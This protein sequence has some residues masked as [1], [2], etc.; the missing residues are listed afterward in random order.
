MRLLLPL[1]MSRK[2][3]TTSVRILLITDFFCCKQGFG[4]VLVFFRPG[5][6]FQEI[7]EYIFTRINEEKDFVNI[8]F[9]FSHQWTV[10]LKFVAFY[11]EKKVKNLTFWSFWWI[12]PLN[13]AFFCTPGFRSIFKIRIQKPRVYRS[14]TDPETDLKP[15]V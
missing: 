6:S 11:H 5:S 15:L 14:N 8:F 13:K 2:S 7:Q 12:F 1:Y 3:F 9:H 10:V 4:S